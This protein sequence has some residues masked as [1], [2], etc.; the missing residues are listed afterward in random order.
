MAT[1]GI[2]RFARFWEPTYYR[3]Y[4]DARGEV[5]GYRS[6]QAEVT[7]AL[8][9]PEDFREPQPGTPDYDRKVSGTARDSATDARPAFVVRDGTYVS[10]RWPGDAHTFA[11]TFAAVLSELSPRSR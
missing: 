10:A 5:A 4:A 7:R 6:V 3:T 8:E 2:G 1:A 11:K 9:K